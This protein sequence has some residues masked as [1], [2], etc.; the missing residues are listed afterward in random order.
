M[1]KRKDIVYPELS[2]LITGLCFKVQNKHGRFCRERQYADEFEK[3][4]KANRIP[5][6]RECN[7]ETFGKELR[8]NK[9]D[10]LI[11]GK[12]LL[13][14]KAKKF[15]TKEDYYQMLRYLE[16]SRLKLG[17]VV[18]FRNTYLKPKRIINLKDYS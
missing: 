4:L 17:L 6:I 15:I 18:N 8:G 13:D 7:L 5:Y 9:V 3:L 2:Y 12:I 16:S 1:I 11:V 10:F 14:I